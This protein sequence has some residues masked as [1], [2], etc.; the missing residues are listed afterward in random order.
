MKACKLSQYSYSSFKLNKNF[1]APEALTT[2]RV[3]NPTI[4]RTQQKA[5][6]F[7]AKPCTDSER[8]EPGRVAEKGTFQERC[9]HRQGV[10]MGACTAGETESVRR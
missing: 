7:S 6:R 1:L 4:C 5:I 2:I 10:C 8:S 9:S 3:K